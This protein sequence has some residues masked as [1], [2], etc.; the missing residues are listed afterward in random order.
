M[1][2]KQHREPHQ[3]L[4]H[5]NDPI[6]IVGRLHAPGVV[7][8]LKRF[9]SGFRLWLRPRFRR[10]RITE[11]LGVAMQIPKTLLCAFAV[12][13]PSGQQAHAQASVMTSLN[14]T[15]KQMSEIP[16]G[17]PSKRIKG[18]ENAPVGAKN[19]QC[20]YMILDEKTGKYKRED[21]SVSKAN[22]A[23]VLGEQSPKTDAGL[24]EFI[25]SG[26]RDIV[27]SV[28]GQ[29]EQAM[30]QD[31]AVLKSTALRDSVNEM[32]MTA[33]AVENS[34]SN[35]MMQS[36]QSFLQSAGHVTGTQP[37]TQRETSSK[38]SGESIVYPASSKPLPQAPVPPII[39]PVRIKKV[40]PEVAC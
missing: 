31:H 6:V 20:W 5:I 10:Y 8:L 12:V 7:K 28:D 15:G 4:H 29:R 30:Q 2:P 32:T 14:P 34:S 37:I 16:A 23:D 19:I 11:T 25:K 39:Q 9:R 18:C 3:L 17:P 13:L 27:G 1:R 33:A 24:V 38:A 21:E 26:L 36:S 40:C 35:D 22:Q